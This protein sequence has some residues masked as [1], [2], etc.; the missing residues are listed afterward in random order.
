MDFV[1]PGACCTHDYRKYMI[2]QVVLERDPA[3][4]KLRMYYADGEFCH[5]C[6]R[7]LKV[8]GRG[9]KDMENMDD[10][11][12]LEE[13]WNK[14]LVEYPDMCFFRKV[15]ELSEDDKARVI[16]ADIKQSTERVCAELFEDMVAAEVEN[17]KESEIEDFV[18]KAMKQMVK[19][20]GCGKEGTTCQ[21]MLMASIMAILDA[22]GQIHWNG[23]LKEDAREILA[24]MYNE[25]KEE[26]DWFNKHVNAT[27]L[28]PTS[29][30]PC[31]IPDSVA[32]KVVIK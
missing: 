13:E 24:K 10:P 1:L 11:A 30:P 9:V 6:R 12:N 26:F 31:T 5:T 27:G 21:M 19:L 18:D 14:F 16:Q 29:P 3:G 2:G 20:T 32:K 25:R 17:H 8:E 4:G 7:V 23:E 15:R 22:G 28:G